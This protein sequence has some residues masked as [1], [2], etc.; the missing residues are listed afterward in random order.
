MAD[1]DDSA[2]GISPSSD[3]GP[4]NE[5]IVARGPSDDA[6]TADSNG[7]PAGSGEQEAFDAASSASVPLTSLASRYEAEQH[8]TYVARLMEALQDPRNRNIAI[9]GRYGS[10]KSSILD[11]FERQHGKTA[12][13]LAIS[14]LEPGSKDATLTN[15]IQKEL[16]K[17]LLYGA[18]LH[19]LRNSRFS[20]ITPRPVRRALLQSGIAVVVI[21]GLL[22][23]LGW[24]PQLAWT[25]SNQGWPVQ[26][27]AWAAFLLLVTSVGAVVRLTFDRFVVS[28]VSAAGAGVTLTRKTSTYFDEYLDEI[29]HYFDSEKKDLVILE[30]LDR[31]DDPQIFEA[32]RELNT[33]L[34]NTPKRRKKRKPLRF[35]YAVR[36]SLF[37][38]LGTDGDAS[39]SDAVIAETD[40]ANRTKFF[41]LVIPLVPFISH[42]NARELLTR[43]LEDAGITDVDRQ[44]VELVAQH[45]TDMRLLVNIRNEYL[46]FAERLL[47]SGKVAPDLTPTDLFALIAYKAFHLEDFEEIARRGSTLDTLYAH[48]RELVRQSIARLEQEKRAVAKGQV[49]AD[50]RTDTAEQLGQRLQTLGEMTPTALNWTPIRVQYAIGTS[51]YTTEELRTP[52]FWRA[53]AEAVEVQLTF[54]RTQ[55]SSSRSLTLTKEPLAQ[56]FPE[57]LQA[58]RWDEID[59]ADTQAELDRIDH[60]IAFLRGADFAELASTDR[61]TLQRDGSDTSFADVINSTLDSALARE[62]I[63]YGYLNRNFALYA[64]QFYGDFTGVDVATFIVQTVQTHTMDID[65]EFTS[66]GAVDNLLAEAGETFTRTISAYNIDVLDHLLDVGD[67]RAGE[68]VDQMVTNFDERAR[69][70]LTSY[71][72]SGK[73]PTRLARQLAAR[74]WREVFTFLVTDEEVPADVKPALVDAAFLAADSDVSYTL[75]SEVGDFIVSH[76]PTMRAFTDPA[77]KA[78]TVADLVERIGV[79][80]PDLSQVD[81]ALRVGLVERD[82]YRISAPNLHSAIGAADHVGLDQV[83]EHETVYR[84]CLANPTAYLAAAE[85]DPATEHT[86]LT[87]ET[88]ATVLTDTADRWEPDQID[89]LLGG[90]SPDSSLPRLE[91]APTATWKALAAARLFLASLENVAAYLREVGSIDEPLAQLLQT[92][93]TITVD[94]EAED[95]E[96]AAED[97]S[98]GEGEQPD[99]TTVAIALLNARHTLENPQDR[100]RLVRSLHP[101]RPLPASRIQPEASNLFALLLTE[102]LIEDAENTFR[103]LQPA[104]WRAIEPAILASSHVEEFLA[105]DLLDGLVADLFGSRKVSAKLGRRVLGELDQFLPEDDARALGAAAR[106]AVEQ[107]VPLPA[108]QVRRIAGTNKSDPQLTMQLLEMMPTL[109][110][111]EIVAVLAELGTPYNNLSSHGQR[112]FDVPDDDDHRAVFKRLQSEGLCTF[113]KRTKKPLLKVKL[114]NVDSH[115]EH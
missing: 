115:H 12:L 107:R 15:R 83:R 96:S 9:T 68:V 100:V 63:I 33:I 13:R 97:D 78:H 6:G 75:S 51:E 59:E 110:V 112:Q 56:L 94:E 16:V 21:G 82:L 25:E 20:R 66:P 80:I 113:R 24:L 35:V 52:A 36:D 72:T 90:A 54:H 84:Y 23:L 46:V 57:A 44:L 2:D 22:Y 77:A 39:A 109:P 65:Y 50:A 79:R 8:Q 91:D 31:F 111:D 1:A 45:A 18:R 7:L 49:R 104:G 89:E 32:L 101:D 62:L 30:D 55:A 73:Q 53:A 48:R 87:S 92:A 14:T 5:E 70:F 4:A 11:E 69:E 29:V 105:P 34:N 58:D 47:E 67:K 102:G 27:L 61:F 103:H 99:K 95:P 3:S 86:I 88:L 37:E 28:N 81:D 114:S 40:R 64:A 38:K 76:Y 60:D 108:D 42:R 85:D 43:L 71:L 17:Q 26:A 98:T 74:G 19:T 93:G 41:D 10:G 106:F